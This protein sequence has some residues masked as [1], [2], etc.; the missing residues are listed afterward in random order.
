MNPTH[1]S[2]FSGCGGFTTGLKAAG[3][4]TLL[5]LDLDPVCLASHRMNHP[6]AATAQADLGAVDAGGLTGLLARKGLV[7]RPVTLA[8]MSP[9]CEPFSG[10]SPRKKA[11]REGDRRRGLYRPAVELA[12]ALG[13]ELIVVE[14][15]ARIQDYPE[16]GRILEALAEAGYRSQLAGVLNAADHGVPQ[17]RERWLVLAARDGGARLRWPEPSASGLRVTVREAFAALPLEPGNVYEGG[18]SDYAALMRD[19]GFW[20]L[21]RSGALAHHEAP[22]QTPA[23]R[24]RRTLVRP[25]RRAKHLRGSLPAG[26]AEALAG[27]GVLPRKD[28][29]QRDHR[30]HWDRP[31]NTVTA[32]VAEEFIAPHGGR[33][34]T[35]REAAR[36]Q[37]FPDAYRWAGRLTGPG[38][39]LVQ[40]VYAQIGDAVP[41]LL[42]YRLGLTIKETS[43]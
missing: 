9:P 16:A 38:N 34:V 22:A 33:P 31:A 5:A 42:A 35:A 8:T 10:A 3:W 25:G 2:L 12:A 27:C 1:V 30:L 17:N 26:I 4:D 14:N 21:R 24:L 18:G 7:T 36:L 6:E 20:G 11:D 39:A 41:P 13:A 29:G 23:M 15:T 28:F 19:D 37:S 40:S 43:T 32:H